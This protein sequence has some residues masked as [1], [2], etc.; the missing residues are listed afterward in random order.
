[1]FNA[2]SEAAK[3]AIHEKLIPQLPEGT[4]EQSLLR[5]EQR[6]LKRITQQHTFT[7]NLNKLEVKSSNALAEFVFKYAQI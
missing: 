3:R 6:I 1:V 2:V 5:L 7:A 4:D